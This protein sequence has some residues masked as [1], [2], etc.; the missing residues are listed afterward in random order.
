MGPL[1]PKNAAKS[2]MFHGKTMENYNFYWEN[3]GKA[4]V[5][6]GKTGKLMEVSWFYYGLICLDIDLL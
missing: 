3:Y 1:D 4:P 5:F 6:N 2:T